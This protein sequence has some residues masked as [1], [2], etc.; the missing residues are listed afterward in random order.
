MNGIFKGKVHS[1]VTVGERGQIVIPA[2]VRQMFR[3]RP[4]ERLIVIVNA[5]RKIIGLMH[6]DDFNAFLK[7]AAAVITKMER[8][9]SRKNR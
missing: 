4:G 1:S 5:E 9:V 7:Q 3:I 2:G 8:K 6:T